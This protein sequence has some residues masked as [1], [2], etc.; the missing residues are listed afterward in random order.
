MLATFLVFNFFFLFSGRPLLLLLPAWVQ[1]LFDAVVVA[2]SS[3]WLYRSWERSADLHQR[4]N[5]ASRFRRH[6]L[7]TSRSK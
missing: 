2:V 4:E 1:T 5:L 3:L 7:C 6:Q